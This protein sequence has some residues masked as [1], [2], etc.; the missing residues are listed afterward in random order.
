[1]R[2][3]YLLVA[4]AV[5]LPISRAAASLMP[6][7]SVQLRTVDIESFPDLAF[8]QPSTFNSTE[9]TADCK[10]FPGSVN[11]PTTE[12]WDSFN[13]S[14]GGALVKSIPPG[15]VCYDGSS[16]S[17]EQCQFLISN[18]SRTRFYL[19]NPVS[20]LSIWPTGSTCLPS[21][22]PSGNCTL[23]GL[24]SYVVNATTVM[25]IQAAVNFARNR[26][27]RLVIK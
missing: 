18:A 2:L 17:E 24:P 14:L 22:H 9:P 20:V 8:G 6:F 4:K 16:Y 27:I 11:W 3:S 7:E 25:H 23:G 26:N 15:A 5:I 21:A 19:D 12:E 10:E 1:M 13:T